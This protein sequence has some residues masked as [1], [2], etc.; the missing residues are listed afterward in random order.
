[1]GDECFK[2]S[3]VKV[4]KNGIRNTSKASI[5]NA[6]WTEADNAR[7]IIWYPPYNVLTDKFIIDYIKVRF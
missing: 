7:G 1:M 6:A 3:S 5:A 4:Y 2:P